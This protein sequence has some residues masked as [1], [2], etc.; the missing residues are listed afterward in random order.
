MAN[1]GTLEI[2]L[3][4]GALGVLVLVLIG[5]FL[6][7]KLFVPAAK[8]F[9]LGLV[10]EM[11]A[12]GTAILALGARVDLSEERIKAHVSAVAGDVEHEVRETASKTGE[13]VAMTVGTAIDALQRHPTNPDMHALTDADLDGHPRRLSPPLPIRGYVAIR[14]VPKSHPGQ[15]GPAQ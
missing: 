15:R 13:Q 8:E 1:N 3:Q 5:L 2:I 12:N 10:A 6:L 11:K 9:L 4:G 7:I 14:P